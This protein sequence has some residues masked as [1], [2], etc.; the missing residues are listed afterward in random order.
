MTPLLPLDLVDD[1]ASGAWISDDGLYR[2]RLWRNWDETRPPMAFVMLNPS[3]ADA[4]ADDPTIRRCIGFAR[5][6]GC[7]GLQ[8]VN[9]YALRAT[10]P[11]HLLD[12]PDPEGPENCAAWA[13]TLYEE[14]APVVVAAWGAGGGMV[15]LPESKA[16]RG[17]SA[18][19]RCLGTTKTGEP[20]HPLYVRGDQELVPW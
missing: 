20:R 18:N 3:T 5:R 9:L 19:W 15:G 12:H 2:Y 17:A 14:P 7:G 13:E 4:T 6:E 16:L 10:R 1:R 8:V 11:V